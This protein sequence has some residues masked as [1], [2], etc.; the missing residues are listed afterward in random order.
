MKKDKDKP[1]NERG[2]TCFCGYCG[3]Y[4]EP[5]THKEWRCPNCGAR[6]Y[7]G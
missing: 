1:R 4:M 6:D 3:T 5:V 2:E 7:T